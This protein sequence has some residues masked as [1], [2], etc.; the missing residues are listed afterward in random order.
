VQLNSQGLGPPSYETQKGKRQNKDLLD[1]KSNMQS[2][3][4]NS[5]R[6][7]T[8]PASALAKNTIDACTIFCEAIVST[9]QKHTNPIKGM[10][11]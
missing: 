9:L 8:L 5:D 3:S 1:S 11:N 2:I 10:E 7:T 4:S 6:N